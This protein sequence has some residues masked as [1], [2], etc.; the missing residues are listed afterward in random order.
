MKITRVLL[1]LGLQKVLI[2]SVEADV[3]LP[4]CEAL[5]WL[6]ERVLPKTEAHS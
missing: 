2:R 3:P 1:A 5:G 6:I 4:V